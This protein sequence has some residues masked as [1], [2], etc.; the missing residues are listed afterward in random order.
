[1]FCYTHEKKP[2]HSSFDNPL[3]PTHSLNTYIFFCWEGLV[4]Y[5]VFFFSFLI[6]SL[7]NNEKNVLSFPHCY[8][9]WKEKKAQ[10]TSP[11]P[12]L[13]YFVS[14]FSI[15]SLSLSVSLYYFTTCF[16]LSLFIYLFRYKTFWSTI[17]FYTVPIL[18]LR[19]R[20]KS[21]LKIYVRLQ[22]EFFF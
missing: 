11:L 16:I 19:D 21:G 1:L 8:A 17:S 13:C 15:L 3:P 18:W 9:S 7:N 22:Q 20:I 4:Q 14:L 2:I 6:I 10:N 12:S 5:S